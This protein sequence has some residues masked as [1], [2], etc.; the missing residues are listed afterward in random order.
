ME[1]ETEAD[2]DAGGVAC[3]RPVMIS[4]KITMITPIATDKLGFSE[5][6]GLFGILKYCN[7]INR[8]F[9][10]SFYRH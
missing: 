8:R 1:G 9:S 4:A 7:L 6:S 5:S 10:P 3:K 2:T